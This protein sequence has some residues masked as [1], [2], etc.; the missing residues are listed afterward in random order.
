MRNQIKNQ[1]SKWTLIAG[2][3]GGALVSALVATAAAAPTTETSE[4]NYAG[5]QTRS[6][7]THATATVESVD[8][9]A[10]MVTLKKEDGD[11]T[12][13]AVPTEVK[14]FD[15]LKKG[16]KVDID[17]YESWPIS[18]APTGSNPSASE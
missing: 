10:R 17:Y 4:S 15:T 18:M 1:L 11:E 7:L 13:V 12:T 14:M 3:A 6:K 9:A 5:G 2:V 16:D 8:H